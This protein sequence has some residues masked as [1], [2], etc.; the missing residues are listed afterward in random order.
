MS[1]MVFGVISNEVIIFQYHSGR[2]INS[3]FSKSETTV[4][5]F[6][7]TNHTKIIGCHNNRIKM[8]AK[9]KISLM[10]SSYTNIH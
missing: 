9:A 2:L 4:S 8:F 1:S 10:Q 5:N 3:R 7:F 6:F